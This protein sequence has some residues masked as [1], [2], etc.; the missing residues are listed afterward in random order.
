[1]KRYFSLIELLIVIAIIAILVGMLLPALYKARDLAYSVN[2]VSNQKQFGTAFAAYSAD[3]G[4]YI[5]AGTDYSNPWFTY[6]DGTTKQFNNIRGLG[7]VNDVVKLRCPKVVRKAG[8]DQRN[9]V[10]GMPTADRNDGNF[11]YNNNLLTGTVLVVRKIKTPSNTVLL[12][13]TGVENEPTISNW[14]L[15]YGGMTGSDWA[16][17]GYM[18]TRHAVTGNLLLADMHVSAVSQQTLQ[19]NFFYKNNTIHKN[20]VERKF[21]KY[22]NAYGVLI[23]FTAE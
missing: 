13:D 11:G 9:F 14:V 2:C 17:K 7:Y 4:G 10:Y 6:I 8:A 1:M 18:V 21:T 12:A 22:L 19:K 3:C 15:N 23:P 5:W 16:I 20:F